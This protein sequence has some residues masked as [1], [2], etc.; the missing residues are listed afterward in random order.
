MDTRT[1][2]L[3]LFGANAIVIATII[4][5]K[6]TE[7]NDKREKVLI[8]SSYSELDWRSRECKDAVERKDEY[9]TILHNREMF[10]EQ[11]YFYLCHEKKEAKFCGDWHM[12]N[13]PYNS[14]DKS[15]WGQPLKPEGWQD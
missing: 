12:D 11:L 3:L 15:K 4:S 9:A 7:D 5:F 14:S 13:Y 2:S 8:D 10:I 6:K 1:Y